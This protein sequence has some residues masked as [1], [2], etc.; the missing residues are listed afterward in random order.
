MKDP[1]DLAEL[2]VEKLLALARAHRKLAAGLDALARARAAEEPPAAL[3]P[4]DEV[5]RA[6]L[7]ARLKKKGF[8]A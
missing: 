6:R 8:A 4:I 3:P 1:D 2:S 5:T 7:R